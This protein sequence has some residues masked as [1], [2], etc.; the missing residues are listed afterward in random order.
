MDREVFGK[1]TETDVVKERVFSQPT[2]GQFGN[3]IA[4]A[5]TRDL[6]TNRRSK[7][8]NWREIPKIDANVH[9]GTDE[10]VDFYKNRDDD[11]IWKY[12]D[13]EI[14]KGQM[15]KYNVKK[16]ILQPTNDGYM[17]YDMPQVNQ[18][19]SDVVAQNKDILK[20][21]AD[22]QNNGSY[23]IDITPSLLEKAILSN[24]LSGL[25]VN[26][27]SLAIDIDDLS[28]VPVLRKAA[29]LEIPVMVQSYPSMVG[30]F[31]A[32]DPDKINRMI[33]VF[34]DINFI[35]ACL[36][37]MKWKDALNG[38]TYVDISYV[39]PKFVEI[40]G[41]EG[42]NRILRAFGA[43]RLIFGTNYP[44]VYKTHALDVYEKY[45]SILEMMDFTQ[46]E[47]EKIA[48]GNI[49]KIMGIKLG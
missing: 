48:Y 3:E 30:S 45:L 26:P 49:S 37:G 29:E 21:F 41:I 18:W 10:L 8:A 43:D 5:K 33:K 20:A 14:I 16:V 39:L 25:M 47:A 13:L 17:Y 40:Y 1:D 22:I 42:T 36:G 2:V 4:N 23:F 7:R 9:L 27:S 28:M 35:T 38:V 15:E 32:G 11:E 24:G 31:S 6:D 44:N 12:S 34:P 46:E 19:L